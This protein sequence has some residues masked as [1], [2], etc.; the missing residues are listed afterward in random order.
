[1]RIPTLF[2]TYAHTYTHTHIYIYTYIHRLGEAAMTAGH[3]E[4]ALGHF[5]GA[6]A[7]EPRNVVALAKRR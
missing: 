3:W 7:L 6:L 1:V 5:N 4:A 2:Y